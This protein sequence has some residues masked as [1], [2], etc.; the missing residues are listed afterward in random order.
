MT[1][2]ET[3]ARPSVVVADDNLFFSARI[4]SAL[5]ALGYHPLVVTTADA[6]HAALAGGPAAAIVNLASR[7]FDVVTAIHRAK[8]DAATQT[9][10]VLGFCGHAD[11]ARQD[12]ARTAGCDLVTTNGMVTSALP[13][14]LTSLLA[15]PEPRPSR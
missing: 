9:V 5:E 3:A 8:T 6:L 4:A 1:S 14:L 13:K 15:V 2:A 7:R 12:A 11:T 10:P